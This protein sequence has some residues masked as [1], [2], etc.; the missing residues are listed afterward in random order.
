ML[1]RIIQKEARRPSR[2]R[3]AADRPHLAV[4]LANRVLERFRVRM[5]GT[6]LPSNSRVREGLQHL[7][8]PSASPCP[9]RS[10]ATSVGGARV[11]GSGWLSIVVRPAFR[12]A[13]RRR[14]AYDA[15]ELTAKVTTAVR[16]AR[17]VRVE[18]SLLG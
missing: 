7:L 6:P 15:T 3:L 4:Q 10:P 18:R 5:L 14:R 8:R 13:A 16:L 12:S 9:I 17:Q 2:D 1:E 11:R